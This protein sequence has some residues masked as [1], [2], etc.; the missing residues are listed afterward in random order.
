VASRSRRAVR[1]RAGKAD[2]RVSLV[3]VNALKLFAANRSPPMI[4]SL[5]FTCCWLYPDV[6]FSVFTSKS[7]QECT[8][9]PLLN[10]NSSPKA[11]SIPSLMVCHSPPPFSRVNTRCILSYL[12]ARDMVGGGLLEKN[13]IFSMYLPGK[14]ATPQLLE[15][16]GL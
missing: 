2:S 10:L 7:R 13:A 5:H 11:A 12:V 15:P 6:G 4:V 16:R 9:L 8:K 1:E 14:L 3:H